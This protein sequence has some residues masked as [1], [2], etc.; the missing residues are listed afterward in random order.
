MAAKGN[1]NA[2]INAVNKICSVGTLIAS[3]TSAAVVISINQ[4]P[5]SVFGFAV[6]NVK[7]VEQK[8]QMQNA[9]IDI[10]GRKAARGK[11]EGSM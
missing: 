5:K 4:L 1:A 2:T 8:N 6:G 9:F 10:F 3:Y 11:V 7:D